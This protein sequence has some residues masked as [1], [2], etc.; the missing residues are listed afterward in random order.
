MGPDY[1]RRCRPVLMTDILQAKWPE[2]K[3]EEEEKKC[4]D[5]PAEQ[6]REESIR[7]LCYMCSSPGTGFAHVYL[8]VHW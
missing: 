7:D 1:G 3:K 5:L 2:K 8:Q 4:A 6:G